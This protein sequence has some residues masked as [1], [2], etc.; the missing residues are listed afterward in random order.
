MPKIVVVSNLHYPTPDSQRLWDIIESEKP[1]KLILLGDVIDNTG[2]GKKVIHLYRDFI[3]V[4]R[5]HFPL[6]R[7]IILLG[8]N[9]GRMEDYSVNHEVE[10]F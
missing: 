7:S 2:S 3:K 6:E 5:K 1:D 4:Y 8:D 9:D 10:K